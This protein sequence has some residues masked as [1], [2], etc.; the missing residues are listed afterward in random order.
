MVQSTD[1]GRPDETP[2]ERI[3]RNWTEILQELRV[4]QAGSQIITGFLLA[5][6]FQERFKD[7]S[8]VEYGIY[9][10]LLGTAIA[11]TIVGMTPVMVHRR[12]FRAG[13]KESIVQ[14]GDRCATAALIG[15]GITLAG[16]VLLIVEMVAGLL[17]GVLAAGGAVVV[18]A[19]LWLVLPGRVGRAAR[20][21]VQLPEAGSRAER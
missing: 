12:L 10:A 19:V 9:F 6:A 11:T 18:I 16:I 15:V 5:A 13:A 4:I 7:L 14:L 21:K 3:A 17:V 2:Q 1:P 20:G 8:S